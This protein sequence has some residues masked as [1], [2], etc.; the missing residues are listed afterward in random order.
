M[1][2]AFNGGVIKKHNEV[3]DELNKE[4]YETLAEF[5]DKVIEKDGKKNG[6]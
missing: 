4:E 5:I 3:L 1:L 6:D 2:K